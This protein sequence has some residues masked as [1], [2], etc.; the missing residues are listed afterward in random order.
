M[1]MSYMGAPFPSLS[2]L[3][4]ASETNID[5]NSA[6]E[7]ESERSEGIRPPA[8]ITTPYSTLQIPSRISIAER[9]HRARIGIEVNFGERKL[10]E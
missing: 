1:Q 2:A 4:S 3:I 6:E 8:E 9:L 7:F 5:G 10:S